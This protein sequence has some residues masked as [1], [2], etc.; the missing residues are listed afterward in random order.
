MCQNEA[1]WFGNLSILGVPGEGYSRNVLC[2]LNLITS[3]YLIYA[4]IVSMSYHYKHRFNS[5]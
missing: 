5:F 2:A 4:Q 3:F 1:T